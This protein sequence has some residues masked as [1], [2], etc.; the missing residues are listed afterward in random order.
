MSDHDDTVIE[1]LIKLGEMG[2]ELGYWAQAEAYFDRALARG[3]DHPAALLGK[4]RASRDPQMALQLV[5]AV[6]THW[7]ENPRAL[8]LEETLSHRVETHNVGRA[9]TLG[10]S[11]HMALPPQERSLRTPPTRARASDAPPQ[12]AENQRERLAP[13]DESRSPPPRAAV[14]PAVATHRT[15]TVSRTLAGGVLIVLV[16][17]VLIVPW[18]ALAPRGQGASRLIL[19]KLSSRGETPILG[20]VLR[21]TRAPDLLTQAELGTALIIAP[22]PVAGE[23]S[24]GSGVVVSEDGLVL[25]NFHVLS[26]D[27]EHLVNSDGLVFVGLT[28]NVRLPPSDWAIAVVLASDP[29]RDLAVLR[30]LYTPEGKPIGQRRF[31]SVAMG[32]SDSL[33]LGQGLIGLGYPTLGG[34]TLTLTRGSMAG[35]TLTEDNVQLGKTDSE[36]LPGSSGGAVLDQD[37]RLV[38]VITAA[39][40]DYRTQGRLS[41]FVLLSEARDIVEQARRAQWPRVKVDWMVEILGDVTG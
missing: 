16:I 31:T 6:L 3:R 22:D 1:E 11:S 8:H 18:D 9:T 21:Q 37:G 40:A 29:V 19:E 41:Y 28:Q 13:R 33:D 25:T 7:P 35:F 39:Y 20:E 17:A 30:I 14:V 24:H 23:L 2:L 36:L 12:P 5:R 32:N 15:P 38:G 10:P 26:L 34:D 4:A 27:G